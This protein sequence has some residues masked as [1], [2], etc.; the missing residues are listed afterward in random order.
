[1]EMIKDVSF[2]L[3]GFFIASI[4]WWTIIV[5]LIGLYKGMKSK[6]QNLM[7]L[8]LDDIAKLKR[9]NVNV[10]ILRKKNDK[11]QTAENTR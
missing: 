9:G 4:L 8:A 3:F 1:M 2:F 6:Y 11:E 5:L 7:Q 10:Y